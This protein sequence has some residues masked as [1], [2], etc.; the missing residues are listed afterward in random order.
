MYIFNSVHPCHSCKSSKTCMSSQRIALAACIW[1]H[2]SHSPPRWLGTIITFNTHLIVFFYIILIS[3]ASLLVAPLPSL[4]LSSSHQHTWNIQLSKL[5]SFDEGDFT[6]TSCWPL[7]TACHLNGSPAYTVSL[8]AC[9][10]D[11]RPLH[12]V[13]P[14]TIPNGRLQDKVTVL[15]ISAT[16]IRVYTVICT[17]TAGSLY[18]RTYL[19]YSTLNSL[20]SPYIALLTTHLS[21]HWSG[22]PAIYCP[23]QLKQSGCGRACLSTVHLTNQQCPLCMYLIHS[24]YRRTP[25]TN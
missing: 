1:R 5:P 16:K 4:L 2:A 10:D 20:P 12:M 15:I 14:N 21:S 3:N 22:L 7:G 8:P 13:Y 18:I 23:P 25:S 6:C 11:C 24:H 19:P 17:C 9:K